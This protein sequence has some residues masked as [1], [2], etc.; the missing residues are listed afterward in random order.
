MD[1]DVSVAI[2]IVRSVRWALEKLPTMFCIQTSWSRRDWLETHVFWK[3]LVYIIGVRAQN[4]EIRQ[5]LIA[6]WIG[7]RSLPLKVKLH[8]TWP[9]TPYSQ[10][11]SYLESIS[12]AQLRC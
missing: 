8:L 11:Q 6:G 12:F 3:F 9:S 2:G 1:S 5:L 7:I 4:G 10:Y